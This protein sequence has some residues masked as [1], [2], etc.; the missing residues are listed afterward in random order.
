M[1][2]FIDAG[3]ARGTAGVQTVH[4]KRVLQALLASGWGA[5]HA[6]FPAR[7]FVSLDFCLWGAIVCA[8]QPCNKMWGSIVR[9]HNTPLGL[10]RLYGTKKVRGHRKASVR[11]CARLQNIKNKQGESPMSGSTRIVF[12]PRKKVLPCQCVAAL[13]TRYCSC[14]SLV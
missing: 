11:L 9:E 3:C 12:G 13:L 6:T 8:R 2:L 5:G 1:T 14:R 10:E 4:K 7:Q